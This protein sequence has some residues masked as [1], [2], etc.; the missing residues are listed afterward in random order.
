MKNK[1]KNNQATAKLTMLNIK[2]AS[3]KPIGTSQG[4]DIA[5]KKQHQ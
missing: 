4:N 1:N 3:S 5:I 2:V